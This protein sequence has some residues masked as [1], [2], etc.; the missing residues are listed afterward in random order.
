MTTWQHFM[1]E[2]IENREKGVPWFLHDKLKCYRFCEENELATVTVLRE[3]NT[4]EE[5][6]LIGLPADYVI[7]PTLQSSTKGVMVIHRDDAGLWD[8]MQKRFVTEQEVYELQSEMFHQTK[9][10]GKKIIVEAKIL[11]IADFDI[12]RD[13]K[14]YCF[15]GEVAL[16]LEINRNFKPSQISWYD[17]DFLPLIDGRITSNPEF[18][19]DVAGVRPPEWA[20]LLDLA[21]RTSMAVPTPFAS[22]DM[23]STPEG[24]IVGEITLAPGGLFHGKHYA[25]SPA[26]QSRM[27]AQWMDA[28][29]LL[30]PETMLGRLNTASRSI[31]QKHFRLLSPDE[32]QHLKVLRQHASYTER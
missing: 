12:P 2:R 23:Y 10:H 11:D 25:I 17:G 30:E 32:Q 26:Q 9:A 14:A 4:P 18:V 7:K 27:G 20:K 24:P 1:V 3:F 13:F 21:K 28:A 15:Q 29:D 6:S 31:Y 8:A 19:K 5:I 22:I 16:I